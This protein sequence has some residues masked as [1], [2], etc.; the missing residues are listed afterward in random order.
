[1][2]INSWSQTIKL[3]NV[4]IWTSS[5][6]QEKKDLVIENGVLRSI[7]DSRTQEPKSSRKVV[8]PSGVDTQVHM[9]VPG[10]IEKESPE[11]SIMAAVAGGVGACLNMPNTRPV[12]DSVEVLRAGQ[13]AVAPFTEKWGAHVLFSGCVSLGQKGQS[14]APLK[15]LFEAG[16]V[17]FTDD[18]HGVAT[19]ELMHQ[20][21]QVLSDLGAP[22]LQ[23]AEMPGAEGPLALGPIQK[24]LGL[25]PYDEKLE[26]DMLARDLAI[27][28][29]YPKARYHLLHISS[30]HCL[31]LLSEAKKSGLKV[32]GEVTPHHLYFSSED[33][34][35]ENKSFKMNPPIRSPQDRTLLARG[36]AEGAID[37]MATDHAPHEFE[38]KQ[39][40]FSGASFGTLGLETSFSVLLK[41]VQD[42]VI[43]PQRLVQVWSSQPAEFLGIQKEYGDVQVGRPFR[44]ILVDPSTYTKV[45]PQK[46]YSQSKNSCFDGVTL[47]GVILAHGTRSGWVEITTE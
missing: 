43:S 21:F 32:T 42:K 34:S 23:H 3:E 14:L 36:L 11:T 40:D 4:D 25:K 6:V 2:R 37:W 22:L 7:S 33:I 24:K 28:Q 5:G 1:M 18:G 41:M 47:P 29:S 8:L 45:Q 15:E 10:Q 12:L 13:E 19:S 26:V 17:A 9:R 44:A 38:T 27:L 35:E 20:A 31:P 16:C 39:K 30:R 46:F